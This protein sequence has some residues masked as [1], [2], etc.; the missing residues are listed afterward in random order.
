[1]ADTTEQ[2][3]QFLL[4]L[5]ALLTKFNASI[6]WTCSTGS[7]MHAIHGEKMLLEINDVA[8]ATIEHDSYVSAYNLKDVL[9]KPNVCTCDEE[10]RRE[11]VGHREE[12]KGIHHQRSC[13]MYMPYGGGQEAG[14]EVEGSPVELHKMPEWAEGFAIGETGNKLPAK[15]EGQ[16]VWQRSAFRDGWYT[17]RSKYMERNP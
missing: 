7:D 11:Y 4:E 15:P 9:P 13:S 8:I 3:D 1:M 17:G 12:V 16:S 10:M 14:S 2:G 6:S 5:H